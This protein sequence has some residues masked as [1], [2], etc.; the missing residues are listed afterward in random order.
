M[1][2][3]TYKVSLNSPIGPIN[4]N[5][6]LI[7]NG[8]NVQGI[9]ETMGMKNNFSGNKIANDKCKFTGNINTPMGRINYNAICT[10]SGNNLQLDASTGYGNFQ[11][12]GTRI[13]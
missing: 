3:G 13:R 8:N 12:V 4:G 7:T 2:D 1:L 5:I 9:I 6:T 11:L 10:I